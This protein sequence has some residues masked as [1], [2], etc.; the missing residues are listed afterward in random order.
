MTTKESNDIIAKAAIRPTSIRILVYKAISELED[1]FSLADLEDQLPTIDKSSIF[2]A[3]TLFHEHHLIHSINDG[4]GFMKYCLC[5]NHG[6]CQKEEV[7]AHFHCEI[8][9]KTFCIDSY[10]IPD[11][12]TPEAF[13]IKEVNFVIKGICAK[14]TSKH[15]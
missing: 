7:H 9:N 2:R 6:S 3:L 8:C 15:K 5:H 4:S 14:C 10:T 12:V 1:T 13:I 11:I